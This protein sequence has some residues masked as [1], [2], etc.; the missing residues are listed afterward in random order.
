[1]KKYVK[2]PTQFAMNFAYNDSL[3]IREA[4]T[5]YMY[6]HMMEGILYEYMD[7]PITP[8]NI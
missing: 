7:A 3:T 2:W 8:L 1:M 4:A 5:Y 6:V